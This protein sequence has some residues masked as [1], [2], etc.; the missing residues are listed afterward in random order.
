MIKCSHKT[1]SLLQR[2]ANVFGE[3]VGVFDFRG[4]LCNVGGY[5]T[6]E[7]E[8]KRGGK[9]RGM[10]PREPLERVVSG[11]EFRENER[12]EKGENANTTQNRWH[13]WPCPVRLLGGLSFTVL[14]AAF[15]IILN[16]YSLAKRG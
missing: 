11:A 2:L 7:F 9:G 14:R 3:D 5:P 15:Y 4:D 12:D 6:C 10:A 13:S 8:G 1:A 16:R